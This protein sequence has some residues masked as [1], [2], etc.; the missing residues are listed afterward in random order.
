MRMSM[1]LSP[2]L[3]VKDRR[4]N[5]ES[6]SQRLIGEP[7]PDRRCMSKIEEQILKANH[8]HRGSRVCADE[9]YVKDRR[10]NSEGKSQPSGD[11]TKL[12]MSCMSKIEEQ[13]LKANHN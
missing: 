10:T 9:L 7:L 2:P 5:S 1:A 8:N 12:R 3:Y 4:T 6:K 11:K 13:I